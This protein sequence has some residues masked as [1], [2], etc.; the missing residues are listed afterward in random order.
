MFFYGRPRRGFPWLLAGI[1]VMIAILSLTFAIPGG[2]DMWRTLAPIF[3]VMLI[4]GAIVAG[5]AVLRRPRR[6]R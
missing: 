5:V 6:G 3:L 1:V 4:V 2:A